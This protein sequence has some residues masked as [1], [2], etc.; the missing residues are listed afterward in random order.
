MNQKGQNEPGRTA[1]QNGCL[2]S[3]QK[4]LARIAR[5]KETIFQ[6]SARTLRTQE[7][8]LRLVLNEAE[9]VAW[10]TMYPHLVF[11]VLA[12]EKVQAIIAWD[13]KRQ[14]VQRTKYAFWG[15]NLARNR[16]HHPSRIEI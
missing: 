13:T 1:C 8:L 15:A 14:A 10:R 9:A 3:C 2:A 11:P 7:H 12:A 5:V 16:N 6:E 4:I